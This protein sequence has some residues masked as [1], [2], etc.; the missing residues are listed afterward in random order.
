[1]DGTFAGM[2]CFPYQENCNATEREEKMRSKLVMF[3]K[4]VTDVGAQCFVTN[5]PRRRS[6]TDF[7]RFV[8]IAYQ[9]ALFYYPKYIKEQAGR[10]RERNSGVAGTAGDKQTIL[11]VFGEKRKRKEIHYQGFSNS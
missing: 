10:T 5:D 6:G 7:V 1:M 11:L 8:Y 4:S 9:C 3:P 2:D